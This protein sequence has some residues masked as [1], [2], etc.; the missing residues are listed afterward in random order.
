MA[1]VDRGAADII[2]EKDITPQL[3]TEKADKLAGDRAK[4][5]EMSENARKMAI[6]DSRERI[7]EVVCDTLKKHGKM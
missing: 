6:L 4:L 2:V 7:Y 3:L 5:D 1:M